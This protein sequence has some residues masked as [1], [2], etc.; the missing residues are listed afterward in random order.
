MGIVGGVWRRGAEYSLHILCIGWLEVA[1]F[2]HRKLVWRLLGI[3]IE[4]Y[5]SLLSTC[6]DTIL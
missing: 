5:F 6:S 3:W 1:H 2:Q 4:S